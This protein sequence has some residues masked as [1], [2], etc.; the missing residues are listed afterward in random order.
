MKKNRSI[1]VQGNEISVINNGNSEFIS[2]TDIVSNLPDGLGL[3]ENWLKNK[4]T[5][6]YLGVWEMLNNPSFNSP[7]FEGIRNTSGNNRFNL[8]VK[9]WTQTTN[10]IG[11][12]AKAG[13]Y[14]GTYAHY[15]I[16]ISFA[17][18]LNPAFQLYLIKEFQRLK[19]NE[20]N[21]INLEWST[22]RLISKAN[23]NIHT[24]A[25]KENII[26]HTQPGREAI[27]Y[28]EEADLLN[29]AVFGYTAKQWRE[30]FPDETMV[31][32]NIRECAN[33][34]QLTV[35]ANCE[36]KNAMFIK[37]G[38][39]KQ[40]RYQ[41]LRTEAISELEILS[42][43]Y[44]DPVKMLSPNKVR[45]NAILAKEQTGHPLSFGETIAKISNAGK[46]QS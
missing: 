44:P 22:K 26:P 37:E 21:S 31:C 41:K 38:I 18:W 4:D 24:D 12:T 13:R 6:E 28:A 46:P 3:I 2:L 5:I 40:T 14:G 16:A 9:R 23:Y 35:L 8:S 27:A 45:L 42:K 29:L 32:Y 17:A 34:I 43:H 19:E 36:T 39:D 30:K 15:D 33:I 10:A 11:I 25:I 7:E 1:V 20:S